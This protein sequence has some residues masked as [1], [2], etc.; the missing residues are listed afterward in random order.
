MQSLAPGQAYSAAVRL[1]LECDGRTIPLAQVADEWVIA[2]EPQ[3]L[4]PGEAVVV[5]EIDGRARRRHVTLPE[6]MSAPVAKTPVVELSAR[7]QASPAG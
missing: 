1:S 5:V 4:P 2:R 7:E 3:S 6:G